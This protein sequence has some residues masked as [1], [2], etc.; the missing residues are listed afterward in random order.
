MSRSPLLRHAFVTLPT[1][2]LSCLVL[3]LC[4]HSAEQQTQQPPSAPLVTVDVNKVLVPVVVRDKHGNAIGDLKKE[5]F[6]VIDSGKPRAISAFRVENH[7]VEK[8]STAARSENAQPAPAS[9]PAGSAPQTASSSPRF[10]VFVFDDL[11]TNIEDLV[12]VQKAGVKAMTEV[13]TSSDIATVL[14][15][16]GQINSGWTQDR[17]KLQ[18]AIM[19][20]KPL[21]PPNNGNCPEIH[22]YE[23]VLADQASQADDSLP[24]A[25]SGVGSVGS[26]TRAIQSGVGSHAATTTA[27]STGGSNGGPADEA[28]LYVRHEELLCGLPASSPQGG[29]DLFVRQIIRHYE[30]DVLDTYDTL[31]DYVRQMANLPGQRQ[32]ILVSPGLVDFELVTQDAGSE[33]IGLAAQ[34][35]VT[36]SALDVRGLYSAF[37]DATTRGK[38]LPFMPPQEAQYLRAEMTIATMSM[39]SL[40]GGT[41]GNFYHNDNDLEAGF[42]ALTQ[43]PEYVY[44][45]ELSVDDVKPDGTYHPLKVKVDRK[46]VQVQ[47]RLAYIKAQAKEKQEIGHPHTE[48]RRKR[49]DQVRSP[50]PR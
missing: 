1:L 18:N 27:P 33:L 4:A 34:S 15:T 30:L 21:H 36:I 38:D 17:A 48:K 32:M 3:I 31:K 12:V 8:T 46:D 22:Y 5:D 16:S 25:P 49:S 19:S 9:A 13:L 40:A 41:G 47:A 20:L 43:L 50:L 29:A 6:K 23:A 14:T 2:I 42:K 28:R 44:E 35:N 45:L 11:H 10:L 7:T 39:A 24:A 37:P 26:A